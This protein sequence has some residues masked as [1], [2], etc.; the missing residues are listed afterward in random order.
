[1]PS[2]QAT[3]ERL[4]STTGNIVTTKKTKLLS[5]HMETLV[6]LHENLK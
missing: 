1:M 3:S 6:F 2:T 4:F 5:I